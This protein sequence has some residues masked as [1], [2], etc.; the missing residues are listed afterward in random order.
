MLSPAR[1]PRPG[2][3]AGDARREH[4][5]AAG[6]AEGGKEGGEGRSLRRSG[7]GSRHRREAQP[8]PPPRLPAGLRPRCRRL[9]QTCLPLPSIPAAIL[10][11]T[12]SR[13]RGRPL[14][15]PCCVPRVNTE[16]EGGL[17]FFFIFFF[18]P[19]ACQQAPPLTLPSLRTEPGFPARQRPRAAAA[20]LSRGRDTP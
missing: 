5:A 12:T 14:S 19:A 18:I 3:M 4:G 2:T 10:R 9:G 11:G 20:R 16:G 1:P 13:W 8:L 17:H 7:E 15:P 6:G